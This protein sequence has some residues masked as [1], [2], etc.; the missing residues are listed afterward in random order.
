M[1]KPRPLNIGKEKDIYEKFL[2]EELNQVESEFTGNEWYLTEE[3]E[4]RWLRDKDNSIGRYPDGW[5]HLENYVSYKTIN[6]E[7]T[8]EDYTKEMHR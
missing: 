8:I 2:D 3:N 6:P 1:N 5:R 4:K 7:A